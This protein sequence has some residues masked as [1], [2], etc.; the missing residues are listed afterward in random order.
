[1]NKN[2]GDTPEQ[3]N[4]GLNQMLFS[5]N[6]TGNRLSSVRNDHHY[7]ERMN[8]FRTSYEERQRSQNIMF[9]QEESPDL[10]DEYDPSDLR[11]TN[12]I[13]DVQ[14]TEAE[15]LQL[16]N[17]NQDEERFFRNRRTLVNIDSRD[18]D[19]TFW[20]K[21]NRYTISLN[22][23]FINIKEIQMRSSEFPNSEQLIRDTPVSRANNKIFWNNEG[24]NDVFVAAILPGNYQ[25]SS[26]QNA[27]QE[28]MNKIKRTDTDAFHE[29]TV[30][31]DSVSNITSFSSLSSE[32]LSNPFTTIAGTSIITVS[33][34][35]HEFTTGTLVNISGSSAFAGLNTSLVNKNQVITVID[36]DTYS[37]DIDVN[38][39]ISAAD[40]GGNSVRIGIG[41]P[42]KLL[43]S[44]PGTP[45]GILGFPLEDTVYSTVHQNTVVD[46]TFDIERVQRID[47]IFSA[48]VLTEVNEFPLVAGENVFVLGVTG[49][50]QDAMVND[51]AGYL[52]STL[53]TVDVATLG[54][55]GT[56]EAR[57]LKIPVAIDAAPIGYGG[58]L[59]TRTLNRPVKLAG[60]NYLFMISPQIGGMVNTGSVR[61]IFAK[62]DLSAPPGTILF[63]T[64][65]AG[66]KKYESPL[67]E[68]Y[69][70]TFEFRDQAGD[71]FDFLDSDHSFTLEVKEEIHEIGDGVGLSSQLGF[72][73]ES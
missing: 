26:L 42:F 27:L 1:M 24:S 19:Q 56:E 16:A 62:I 23:K 37:F 69:E 31:I 35:T 45:A 64:F 12:A 33:H 41:Q 30:S 5:N 34:S 20:P 22:R 29:F 49:T 70:L 54:L 67:T 44:N 17:D 73:D 36:A 8:K 13:N 40:A 71:L 61:N 53:T 59:N 38:I 43:F 48:V 11:S 72:R 55:T 6:F 18:R 51:A 2:G 25:P 47:S 15:I 66:P 21:P 10:I 57:T 4:P 39:V 14:T 68:L 3:R 52:M 46:R 50:S 9:Q 7:L 32:Q 65:I 28:S 58:T 63:N 60:E